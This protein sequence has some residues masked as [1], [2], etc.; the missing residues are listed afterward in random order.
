MID[1]LAE[2]MQVDPCALRLKNF[3]DSNTLTVGQFRITSNGSAESLQKVMELSDWKN[4]FGKMPPGHGFGVACGF[5][6]SGSALP[7]HWN[8]YPQ[9]VV[10]LKVDMD[11]RVLIT[12]GASDIGQGSDTMLAIVVAEVLG[13]SMDFIFV[14]AADTTLTPIDLGSY[15]SRVTF[16]A[17]NAAKLAAENLREKILDA[18]GNLHEV[19]PDELT[20]H[21]ERVYT[22]DRKVD[23]SWVEAIEIATRKVGALNTSGAYNSPKLG[24]DFKGAGAGL[25]PSYSFGAVI[26]EVKVDR[27]TG[28]VNVLNIW[29]AHD[30][31]KALNPLAVEGQL[32]GSW[33]MGLGQAMGEQMKYYNGLLVNGNLLDY[34]IPTAKD[35][36]PIHTA[37][38]E[39]ADPEGPFGAKECGEGALHPVIP[40]IANA[41]Y[42]A[43]GVRVTS[44]PINEEEL[45]IALKEKLEIID[46]SIA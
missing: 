43:V 7:I 16:M 4:K 39:T 36:P 29:G 1:R 35:T 20:I 27:E 26:A 13:L 33:H 45:L 31:G 6:I 24:G 9:S 5:F 30:V 8:E 3:F 28:K 38:I 19:D 37:I 41:I 32:E 15:S 18:V 23:L 42:D 2:N 22:S 46:N 11:G 10:H 25:S 21:H 14:V 34:K 12:S 44:L 40:A 17:G